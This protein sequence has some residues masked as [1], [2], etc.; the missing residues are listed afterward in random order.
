MGSAWWQKKIVQFRHRENLG[1]SFSCQNSRGG[2]LF[3][4][5]NYMHLFNDDWRTRPWFLE[6]KKPYFLSA[7][8]H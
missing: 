5:T 1:I 4:K 2:V 3:L 6:Q 7:R 8:Q